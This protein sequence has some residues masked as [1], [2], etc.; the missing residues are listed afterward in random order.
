MKKRFTLIELLVVIAIIAILAAMLLP[1]LSQA[2]SKAKQASCL[3]Q[4]KQLDLGLVMYADDYD[5]TLMLRSV[6]LGMP[7]GSQGTN[8]NWWRF[9]VQPY[10]SDW[11]V[12][13]CPTGVKFTDSQAAD[14][15]L[16]FHR[17]YGYNAALANRMIETIT[18]PAS[19]LSLSDSS[20]W[21]ANGCSGRSTAWASLHNRVSGC[22]A[23]DSGNWVPICTR[24]SNGSNIAYLDG[25][26]E[27]QSALS[28]HSNCPAIVTP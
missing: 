12:F 26:A 19:L 1:A 22:N 16:Q 15:R 6:I 8:V 17:T 23:N 18:K 3:S 13:V 11:S 24:H 4:L 9:Y 27:W 25:H 7:Q 28:I 21:D 14:S 10:V 2:R 5:G 20:H